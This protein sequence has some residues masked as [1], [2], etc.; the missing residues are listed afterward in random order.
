MQPM[1]VSVTKCL[2]DSTTKQHTWSDPQNLMSC[3][4]SINVLIG[5]LDAKH[6]GQKKRPQY[7]VMQQSIWRFCK[8]YFKCFEIR[9]CAALLTFLFLRP[10][11]Q[12]GR[13]VHSK[14]PRRLQ[15][16]HRALRLPLPRHGSGRRAGKSF[17]LLSPQETK[18][19]QKSSS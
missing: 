15:V 6:Q 11:P 4:M 18:T 5:G 14:P 9:S 12:I 17:R 3:T 8:I 16:W 7:A 13:G 1:G 2:Q 10:V 19:G